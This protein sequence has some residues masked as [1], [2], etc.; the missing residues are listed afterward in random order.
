MSEIEIGLAIAVI[1]IP[2]LASLIVWYHPREIPSPYI[3]KKV[4]I[5]H[6]TGLG[7]AGYMTADGV[8][9]RD[10]DS[11][12]EIKHKTTQMQV[13]IGKSYIYEIT[14]FDEWPQEPQK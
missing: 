8:V 11:M 10:S 4:R 1:V 13:A 6:A 5:R 9:C 2:T 14:I 7:G 12:I 3:G